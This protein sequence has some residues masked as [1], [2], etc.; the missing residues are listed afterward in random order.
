MRV[1]LFKKTKD[2]PIDW[3]K[4]KKSRNVGREKGTMDPK[5][6]VTEA[7]ALASEGK[8]YSL[9]TDIWMT[10]EKSFAGGY[11]AIAATE[12]EWRGIL[13]AERFDL[14]RAALEDLVAALDDRALSVRG[15][16][17]DGQ[18]TPPRPQSAAPTTPAS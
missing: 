3:H 8:Y 14:F 12:A 6:N 4:K 11:D 5:S 7:K 18:P 10:V 16:P 15:Q 9:T 2:N 13:G 17:R 1:R